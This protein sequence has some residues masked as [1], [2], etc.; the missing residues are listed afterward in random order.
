MLLVYA[1]RAEN[2]YGTDSAVAHNFEHSMR[3]LVK[4]FN[5]QQEGRVFLRMYSVRFRDCAEVTAAPF[6]S[7]SDLEAQMDVLY[8]TMPLWSVTAVTVLA[9]MIVTLWRN[10][11]RFLRVLHNSSS[12]DIQVATP[13]GAARPLRASVWHRC[14]V[15]TFDRCRL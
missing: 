1:V 12:P 10:N 15:R 14:H 5:E 4:R 3:T 11:V 8:A 2:V 6:S 7:I 13:R 9:F